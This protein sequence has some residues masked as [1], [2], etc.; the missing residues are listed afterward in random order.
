MS[1]EIFRGTSEQRVAE[2]TE[3]LS[4]ERYIADEQT[5]LTAWLAG[6]LD[7]PMLIEGDPGVGKTELALALSKSLN[8]PLL[9]LQCY[10]GI[11]DA[12][13]LYE[14]QYGKQLLYTQLLRSQLDSMST[15]RDLNAAIEVLDQT[16]DLFYSERFLLPRPLLQAIESP[17]PVVLLVD[18]IDKADGEFEALLLEILSGW[19][20]TVPELGLREAK[21]PPLTI[22]TS[23]ATRDIGDALRRRCLHLFIDYPDRARE[24]LIVA[25]RVP[26]VLEGLRSQL[27]AFVHAVRALDIRKK[28]AVSE[29]VEWARALALLHVDVLGSD[30]V[31]KTLSVLMKYRRDTHEVE[32]QIPELLK[33]VHA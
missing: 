28:P 33:A 10:E 12:K 3:K 11:D 27:V 18:E 30:V 32:K 25:T 13:A 16:D 23:N 15:G 17:E 19:S 4:S 22:L 26:E 7:K 24:E 31:R 21:H 2:L 1:N 29:T 14:W 8:R 6:A 9:R 5:V 20:I